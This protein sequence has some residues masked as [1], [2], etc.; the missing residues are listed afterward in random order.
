M[1]CMVGSQKHSCLYQILCIP[2]VTK[3]VYNVPYFEILGKGYR[4]RLGQ[5][6]IRYITTGVIRTWVDITLS[7]GRLFCWVDIMWVNL[8]EPLYCTV[9]YWRIFRVA[10]M[11][12]IGRSESSPVWWGG[13]G[14]GGRTCGTPFLEQ[15]PARTV[16]GTSCA[17]VCVCP[18]PPP[19]PLKR[20]NNP[21]LSLHDFYSRIATQP[22]I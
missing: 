22:P 17:C 14:G 18:P 7:V 6:D 11:M 4:T 9:E 20:P 8:F 10:V 5:T 21:P 12:S 3:H 1:P 16:L 13:G 19:R 2:Y 15:T